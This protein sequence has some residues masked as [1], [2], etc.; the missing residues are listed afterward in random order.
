MKSDAKLKY[1]LEY[2]NSLGRKYIWY[3]RSK[4]NGWR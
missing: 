1:L 2:E 4:F 3:T